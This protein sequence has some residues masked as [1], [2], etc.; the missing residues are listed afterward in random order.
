[1]GMVHLALKEISSGEDSFTL[2][3]FISGYGH[4]TLFYDE[5]RV[6]TSASDKW[7]A[8]YF[9]E[10]AEKIKSLLL[11]KEV[12]IIDGD[13]GPYLE[14]EYKTKQMLR[15]LYKDSGFRYGWVSKLE[16]L[17]AFRANG[18]DFPIG[19]G[20]ARLLYLRHFHEQQRSLDS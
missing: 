3:V 16:M 12:V 13:Y 9:G 19:W 5:I 20:R 2:A 10:K 14:A 4:E 15:R 17:V 6:E 11:G 1:M 8:L 7:N 18:S